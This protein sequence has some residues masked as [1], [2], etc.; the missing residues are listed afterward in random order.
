M[1]GIIEGDRV[2]LKARLCILVA[3]ERTNLFVPEGAQ[4][5]AG[6]MRTETGFIFVH[7]DRVVGEPCLL[8]P[9]SELTKLP[10][11]VELGLFYVGL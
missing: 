11:N 5:V 6:K 4:G 7:F 2:A 10:A 3:N 1:D 9:V 8:V